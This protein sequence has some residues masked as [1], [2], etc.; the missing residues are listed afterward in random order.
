MGTTE[1][2][3]STLLSEGWQLV[4]ELKAQMFPVAAA[5]WLRVPD[6]DWRLIIASSVVREQGPDHAYQNIQGVLGRLP[7]PKLRITD[8]WLVKDTDPVVKSVSEISLD[9][10]KHAGTAPYVITTTSG[11]LAGDAQIYVTTEPLTPKH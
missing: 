4:Q 6:A 1:L 9:R 5:F 2:V 8:V 3:D 7:G 10:P 11:A